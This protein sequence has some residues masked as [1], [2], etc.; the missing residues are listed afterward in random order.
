MSNERERNMETIEKIIAGHPI[1]TI[2]NTQHGS[3][4]AASAQA[5]VEIAGQPSSL[6]VAPCSAFRTLRVGE[7]PRDGDQFFYVGDATGE[8]RG[9]MPA[10]ANML[11]KWRGPVPSWYKGRYRR[12]VDSD[13]MRMVRARLAKTY[14][15]GFVEQFRVLPNPASEPR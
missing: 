14:R 6:A 8:R 4:Q 13:E 11:A 2:E 7:Y 5:P 1:M 12:P 15:A 3:T 9:W 10:C